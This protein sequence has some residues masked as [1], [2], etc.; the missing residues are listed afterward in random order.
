MRTFLQFLREE[1]AR[2]LL[3]AAGCAALFGLL[4]MALVFGHAMGVQ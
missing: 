2:Y 4:W 1:L 3:E